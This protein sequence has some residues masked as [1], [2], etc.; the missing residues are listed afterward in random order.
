MRVLFL[1]FCLLTIPA[2]ADE[3][4]TCQSTNFT[5]CTNCEIP[6]KYCLSGDG[7]A[8]NQ[9]LPCS[10]GAYCPG[11]QK[12][13]CCADISNTNGA[14]PYSDQVCETI[15]GIPTC[16]I[17]AKSKYECY[18]KLDG[19]ENTAG[20]GKKC[21]DQSDGDIEYSDSNNTEK[22]RA[23]YRDEDQNP[24]VSCDGTTGTFSTNG[25]V[26]HSQNID[27]A[28]YHMEDDQCYFNTRNCNLF[29]L[30]DNSC[31]TDNISGVLTWGQLNSTELGWRHT[32][33]DDDV[34]LCKRNAESKKC[35]AQIFATIINSGDTI[36]DT[37]ISF[38]ENTITPDTQSQTYSKCLGCLQG[39]WSGTNDG[40]PYA[41]CVD[42]P[43][44]YY[45]IG[46]GILSN[47]NIYH[48]CSDYIVGPN[49]QSP[50]RFPCY[51]GMTS[52]AGSDAPEDCHYTNATN[53][54]DAYGCV[55]MGQLLQNTGTSQGN[56]T[57]Y[58]QQ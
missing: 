28:G 23:Y 4:T 56:W 3:S 10:E 36:N 18:K 31:D 12:Q 39:A 20:H 16:T 54:C 44:G 6:G 27:S 38:S 58:M 26:E 35:Y 45:S 51:A 13:Y 5:N 22:C 1:L 29:T 32:A 48:D 41:G 47:S 8:G 37:T 55:T 52:A 49:H 17:G 24:Y 21:K 33:A 14:F 46:C 43:A 11:N 19:N 57:W 30:S 42:V 25:G 9:C 40:W 34:C 2:F 53:F 50:Y 15:A 7:P